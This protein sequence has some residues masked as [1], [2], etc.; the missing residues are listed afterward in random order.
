MSTKT[1]TPTLAAVFVLLSAIF[2]A[3]HDFIP[4]FTFQGSSLTG[5]HPMGAATWRA[6]N[7]EII[8]TPQSPEGGWLVMD[9][10]YQD[11]KFYSEFR[12]AD[13]CD[14]GVLLRAEKIPE[15]GRKGVYVALTG[16]SGSYDLTLTADGK[17]LKRTPLLR[18]TAQFARMAAGPWANG[19]ANVP[20]FARPAITL[21][22]QQE[23]AA[24]PPAAPAAGRGGRGGFAPPRPELK[25]GD[26]NTLDI[27][28]DT[29]MV[30]TTLNG[31]RGGNSAPSDRMMGYGPI[32][33]HAGGTGEVRFKDIAI[34]DLN[35]KTEPQSQVS[36]HFRM[37]QL[38]DFFYS[39][40]ATAGDINHDGIPDV[41]AGPFYFLGPDY[42]VR[43]E[44]TAARSYS[45]SNNF[46]EGHNYF[47]YDYTGDGW[48]DIICV[49]SRPI[50][51]FV[52]PKGE[53]RRW[54]R[55]NIVPGATSEVEVF[56]D[57][58]GDG[59]PDILFAGPGATMAYANPDPANPTG[60]WK[61]HTISDPGLGGPH[62]M[63]VG[64]INGDGRMD[65]VNARGWWEQ[66]ASGAGETKW[67]FHPAQ[68][69]N[70]G[71]E[72]G[73]YDVNGDGLNDVVTAI[74][75]H[76]FGLAWF[77]QKRDAQGNISFVRHD[78]MGDFSAK[79]AGGVTFSEP[80]AAAFADM[81][82]DGVPDMIV[83]KR[84]YSHLESH[85]DPDPYGPAVLYWYRTV[86]NP[87][88]EG[89]AEFVPELIHNRSGVGS[90]FVVQ[91]LNGDG[92]PDIVISCVKGTFVFW[93]QMRGQ[94]QSAPRKK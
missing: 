17:Q 57:I 52:N 6:E 41:I 59:K 49:N 83:G 29:D 67:K 15:G 78:I 63:G 2:A 69:G 20:G 71:A 22:E 65:V 76:T 8:A 47:A 70:G 5:W 91:D 36:S 9:K 79:N 23:E 50:Y 54:D 16:E 87:K 82:G 77:E 73:V 3:T 27:I 60:L 40:G 24:K 62:G 14:A 55:Y 21:E 43:H 37:Q 42:T 94:H 90:Q 35:R 88:A 33:L 84:L 30:T 34:K 58:D 61:V 28:V 11:V 86:R 44:F 48:T 68:F 45:P 66:P 7:G 18:A 53:N 25:T 64:D 75:A 32:A 85:L 51:L 12:C 39:W 10:G 13:K 4:D 74:A 93:N 26:W 81:D 80:H 31:R 46:P 19:S 92:A 89:G 1:L 72:M 38:S 56:R